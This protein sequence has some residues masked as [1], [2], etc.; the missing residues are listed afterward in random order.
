M[1]LNGMDS[2]PLKIKNNPPTGK[3]DSVILEIRLDKD[4]R[5]HVIVN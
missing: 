4:C 2:Y 1:L 3:P 5:L